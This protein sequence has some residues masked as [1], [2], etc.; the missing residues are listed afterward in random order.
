MKVEFQ[1]AFFVNDVEI[2]VHPGLKKKKETGVYS[3]LLF[4]V[5]KSC[6]ESI[7]ILCIE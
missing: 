2:E 3:Y 7:C 6:T 4:T 5:I 1:K